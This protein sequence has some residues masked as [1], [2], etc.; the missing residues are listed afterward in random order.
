VSPNLIALILG[1]L[2]MAATSARRPCVAPRRPSRSLATREIPTERSGRVGPL[3]GLVGRLHRRRRV[4]LPESVAAWCDELSRQVR[5][6]CSLTT[7]LSEAVPNDV[8]VLD[9]TEG[10]RRAL[11]R[12][13]SVTEAVTAPASDEPSGRRGAHHLALACSMIAVSARVGGTPAAPLD[14]VAASLR[15]RAVDRQERATNAAQAQMSARVLTVL[16]FGMLALLVATDP[17]VRG[18]VTGPIG[19][20]CVVVGVALNLT[21]YTWMR[22]TIGGAT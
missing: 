13:V 14:R 10:L 12:G 16:P 8:V 15:L 3:L 1:V 11:A 17:D 9:A 7:A 4:I 22:H 5:A 20:L 18:A 2:L 6:G 21:G 19:G